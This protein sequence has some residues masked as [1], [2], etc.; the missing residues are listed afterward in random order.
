ME[1]IVYNPT[2]NID[3]NQIKRFSNCDFLKQKENVLNTGSTGARKI[4]MVRNLTSNLLPS[5]KVMCSN[6]VKLTTI[7]KT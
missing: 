4:Y 2:R 3:K 7:L 5:L 1:N 6:T